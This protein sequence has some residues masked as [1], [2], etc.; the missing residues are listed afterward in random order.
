MGLVAANPVLAHLLT[1]GTMRWR[2][3]S[4]GAYCPV[5]EIKPAYAVV[6]AHTVLCAVTSGAY[7]SAVLYA[8]PRPGIGP[9]AGLGEW[10]VAGCA[11]L[12]LLTA[13]VEARQSRADTTAA[14]LWSGAR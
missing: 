11:V 9:L 4:A 12:T 7:A 6:C 2:L 5:G 14:P 13:A 3:W 1:G 10:L 8:G